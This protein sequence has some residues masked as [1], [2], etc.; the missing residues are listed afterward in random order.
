M[1]KRPEQFHIENA[2]NHLIR[3]SIRFT[4]GDDDGSEV[5]QSLDR[6]RIQDTH[7]NAWLTLMSQ[8]D[9]T[10]VP[11]VTGKNVDLIRVR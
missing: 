3:A 5:D 11:Q 2:P 1:A 9:G 8:M 4:Q 7:L 10:F 6:I